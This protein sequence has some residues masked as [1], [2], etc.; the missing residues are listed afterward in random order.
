MAAIRI[1]PVTPA[2]VAQQPP[3]RKQPAAAAPFSPRLPPRQ[4]EA[5]APPARPPLRKVASASRKGS[6]TDNSCSA[7]QSSAQDRADDSCCGLFS[8]LALTDQQGQSAGGQDD[9]GT[10][11]GKA[12]EAGD[13]EA[14]EAALDAEE[15]LDLLPAG[16]D[17]GIFEV[18]LPG[19]ETLGVAV[20]L[21]PA[22][23]SYLITAG[24]DKTRS[25][26]RAKKM[27][28]EQGLQR[29]M[30]RNIELAIL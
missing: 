26:L 9:G 28:L 29:R 8:G 22:S 2:S 30:H 20:D 3:V 17:S 13:V 7:W 16:G 14:G 11:S 10:E 12:A 23:A 5:P 6:A 25:M 27:E 24:S 1:P 15:L 19:G 21:H 4:P 18:L